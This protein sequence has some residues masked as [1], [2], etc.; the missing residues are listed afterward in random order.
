MLSDSFKVFDRTGR[1]VGS[2]EPVSEVGCGSFFG[3]AILVIV[4]V[5]VKMMV[6]SFLET[7]TNPLFIAAMVIGF[8]PVW[9]SI[10]KTFVWTV[11]GWVMGVRISNRF[12]TLWW[13]YYYALLF[14][15]VIPFLEVLLFSVDMTDVPEVRG[16]TF[17][18]YGGLGCCFLAVTLWAHYK[19]FKQGVGGFRDNI[20]VVKKDV[21]SK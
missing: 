13:G 19:R 4:F 1:R 17:V 9:F 7:V 18:I 10:I 20:V 21:S 11:Y 14:F 8:F 5:V 16:V 15:M 12:F 6:D 3:V 2:L